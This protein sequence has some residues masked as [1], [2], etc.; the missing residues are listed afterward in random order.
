MGNAVATSK[1]QVGGRKCPLPRDL[2]ATLLTTD[3]V[4]ALKV[5]KVDD[6]ND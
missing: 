4:E 1:W 6:V 5:L 3:V 2:P